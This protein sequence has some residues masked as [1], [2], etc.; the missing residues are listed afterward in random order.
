MRRKIFINSITILVLLGCQSVEEKEKVVINHEIYPR[1]TYLNLLG[2]LN[3]ELPGFGLDVHDSLKKN[4]PMAYGLILS[5]EANR[6]KYTK[7]PAALAM[8]RTCG[9]WLVKNSDLNQNGITGYGLSDPWDA[10]G[11]TSVNPIHQ[12]YT[13]TTAGVARALM[14]WS[15]IEDNPVLARLSL[16]VALNSLLPYVDDTFDSPLGIPAYSPPDYI[17][18]SFDRCYVTFL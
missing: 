16:K 18:R 17:N 13:I 8:V 4:R 7:D 9:K 14:D 3:I 6:Y 10:F 15:E 1:E 11:D 2:N 5:A 12:E